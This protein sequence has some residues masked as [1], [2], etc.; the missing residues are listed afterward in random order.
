MNI[1]AHQHF[2]QYAPEEYLWITP[3]LDVLQKDYLPPDLEPLLEGQGLDGSVAVQA[4][5]S[6]I[7]TEWLLALAD[8]H[9]VIKGVVGWVDL[10]SADC[11]EQLERFG[12]HDRFCGVRHVLQDEEDDE[13]ML[14]EDFLRGVG[15]LRQLELTY[16]LLI[17]PNH[18]SAAESFVRQLE[19]HRIVIDHIAKPYIRDREIAPWEDGIR[20]LAAFDHVYCKVSGMVTEADPDDLR[21]ERFRPYLDVVFDAFGPERLMFGSDWPVCL[22]AAPYEKVV[23][24]VADYVGALSE[25]ERAHV[26]GRTASSFYALEG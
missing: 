21:S 26:W 11:A 22:L 25:T 6:L 7:E 16:D 13:Y 14:R 19:G 10:C 15:L 20:R 24:V 5:Q 9:P 2:W 1:D 12:S 17:R 23:A 18:L 4:R 8:A 3:D